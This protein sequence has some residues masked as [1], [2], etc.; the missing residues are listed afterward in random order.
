MKNA[1]RLF[2]WHEQKVNYMLEVPAWTHLHSVS[3]QQPDHSLD[4]LFLV[5]PMSARKVTQLSSHATNMFTGEKQLQ[6]SR[7]TVFHSPSSVI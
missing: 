1:P 2:A 4:G 3:K 6:N 5:Q 7:N